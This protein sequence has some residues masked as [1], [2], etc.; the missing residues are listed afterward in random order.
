MQVAAMAP[1]NYR[2]KSNNVIP[3]KMANSP[4]FGMYVNYTEKGIEKAGKTLATAISAA[5]KKAGVCVNN[6]FDKLLTKPLS[7]LLK[8]DAN[9][10][11][12]LG[13]KYLTRVTEY[14]QALRSG[15]AGAEPVD[16]KDL[17]P[18]KVA[19]EIRALTQNL[20][21]KSIFLRVKKDGNNNLVL[22][23]PAGK[24][25]GQVNTNIHG[26]NPD[27]M[28]SIVNQHLG[29]V[30]K[31]MAEHIH[32]HPGVVHQTAEAPKKPQSFFQALMSVASFFL[33]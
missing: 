8:S 4:S 25:C 27:D 7:A 6:G 15:T 10:Q 32:K 26:H 12:E 2:Q 20:H 17:L 24:Y 3:N 28:E 21:N 18:V 30:A 31:A 19:E 14:Q 23:T 16:P 5:L 22:N 29:K 33:N 13:T 11:R 1:V 9:A